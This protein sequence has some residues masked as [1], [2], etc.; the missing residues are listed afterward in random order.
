MRKTLFKVFFL[1]QLSIINCQLSIADEGMWLPVFLKQLN[2]DA[3]IKK[4]LKIPVDQIYSVNN[5]SM[6]DAVVLFGGG[7]TAEIISDKGLILTNH[8]C[9][10]SSIQAQSSVDHDYLTNGYWAMTQEQ[11]LPCPNLTVTFIVRIDDV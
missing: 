2:E 5:S 10:Y 3:M 6:K 4:G 7:C 11:E 1:F 9:G 8:H